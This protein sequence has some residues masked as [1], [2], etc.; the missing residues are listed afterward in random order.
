MG[1]LTAAKP[2]KDSLEAVHDFGKLDWVSKDRWKHDQ[3][4]PKTTT[5]LFEMNHE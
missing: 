2:Q 3:K 4:H 5:C 1:G